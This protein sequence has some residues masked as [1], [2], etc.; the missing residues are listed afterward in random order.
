MRALLSV[1]DRRG[2][3]DLAR[4]LLELGV[5]VFAT[6]GTREALEADGLEVAPIADLTAMPSIVGGQVKTFH[7]QVYAGILARRHVADADM[8]S[9][10]EQGIGPSTSSSSTSARS[11]PRSAAV[12]SRST[13]RSR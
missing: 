5:E 4:G 2:I 7:P 10:A 13:R 9:L 3:G 12:F 1:A 8:A 11:R 6:D